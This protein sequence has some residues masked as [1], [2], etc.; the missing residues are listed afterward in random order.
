MKLEANTQTNQ[1]TLSW[2]NHNLFRFV[3]IYSFFFIFCEM[4]YLQQLTWRL[5]Q[6]FIETFQKKRAHLFSDAMTGWLH[7]K[8]LDGLRMC[9]PDRHIG[10]PLAH[11]NTDRN[12]E[13]LSTRKEWTGS[14]LDL[15]SKLTELQIPSFF[16]QRCLHPDDS[17]GPAPIATRLYR[18]LEV[19]LHDTCLRVRH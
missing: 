19:I 13:N 15:L 14:G 1:T 18:S 16:L 2:I 11:T 17:P 4:K 10:S 12:A 5:R 3:Q 6:H 7:R 8:L 9:R